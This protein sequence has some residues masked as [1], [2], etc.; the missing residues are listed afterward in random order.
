MD[1]LISIFYHDFVRHNP[2]SLY[3][4][5]LISKLKFHEKREIE[6]YKS[7]GEQNWMEFHEFT[8]K[9]SLEIKDEY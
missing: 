1:A 4:V 9:Y 5:D 8:V 6:S 7:Y 2:L 3:L